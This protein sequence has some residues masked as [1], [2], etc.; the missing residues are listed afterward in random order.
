MIESFKSEETK[1]V[2]D[3]TGSRK[4]PENIQATALRRLIYLNT[5][6]VFRIYRR[7]PVT[8]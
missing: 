6:L 1:K 8:D 7:Y 5:L 2:F 3:Q 4:L